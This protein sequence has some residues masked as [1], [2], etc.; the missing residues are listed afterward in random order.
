[1]YVNEREV[2][3]MTVKELIKE[4]DKMP[5]DARVVYYDGDNGWSEIDEVQYL[6]ELK[7]PYQ[8]KI[9]RKGKFVDLYGY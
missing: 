3:T 1:M 7:N 8:N 2:H 6:T 5:Q 4:L 9:E